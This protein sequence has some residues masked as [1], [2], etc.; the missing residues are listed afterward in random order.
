MKIVFA[1]DSFKGSLTSD[2]INGILKQTSIK[3]F[4]ESVETESLLIADGGEG[5][6]DSLI[7]S[8]NGKIVY[9]T[10]KDPLFRDIESRYGVFDDTA[11]ISM[12]EA[13]G[14]PILKHN[15]RNPLK[16]TTFGTGELIK[17]AVEKG[18]KNLIVTIGGSATNDGG[19]GALIALGIKFYLRDGSLAIGKGEDLENI[20]K[21]DLSNLVDFSDIKVTV[22]SDV[23]NP[24]LGEKG[25]SKVFAKQKGAD[26][27]MIIRLEK[28]MGNYANVVSKTF[29]KPCDF[30]GAGAAGGLGFALKTFL[31][32]N[33]RSGIDVVLDLINFD[34]KIK[35]A[36]MVITGE[37]RIDSQSVDGKVISGILKRTVKENVPT[38]A[39]VGSVGAGAEKAYE[40]GLS[41]I[42]SIIDKPQ[43]LEEILSDSKNLYAKTAES[44]FRT[45]KSIK[46]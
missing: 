12:N 40:L 6:L 23:T 13:S 8:K 5:T 18:Y 29:N 7:K 16:T 33:M 4:G 44:L 3:V 41:G 10:V 34:E 25:A 24:L 20:E 32:A 39:I 19:I 1:S 26:E 30:A 28:G 35:G 14:L 36:D 38:F 21:I 46:K 43:K 2:D 9:K 42:Y 31:N 22:L 45:V 37:G 15:E 27:D 11:V 17:D